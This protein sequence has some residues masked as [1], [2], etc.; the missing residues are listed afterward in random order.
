MGTNRYPEVPHQGQE[1]QRA[2][3]D[4]ADR[5]RYFRVE[6]HIL[7]EYRLL[8][9]SE[10]EEIIKAL[11]D[12]NP[13]RHLIASSFA[14]TSQQM[15]YVLHKVQERE[16][17]IALYLQTLNEK[18]DLLARQLAMETTEFK[19][20]TPRR[21]DVSAAGLG[22]DA[23]EMIPADQLMDIKMMLFPSLDY[24]RAVGRVVRCGEAFDTPA[25]PAFKVAVDFDFVRDD[26]RELLIQ[27]VIR[28]E[29]SQLREERSS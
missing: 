22:F 6:D 25:G 23:P 14:N 18:L 4:P 1:A 28:T 19:D 24:I 10:R 7:L 12:D 9:D 8:P 2:P 17:E 26:D 16:P 3:E 15:Q 21:V 5:R 13:S 29:S 11:R 20:R 27:H